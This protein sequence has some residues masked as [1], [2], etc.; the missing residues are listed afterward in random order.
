MV[1]GLAT[2][3]R[4][5]K[6]TTDQTSLGDPTKGPGWEGAYTLEAGFLSYFELLGGFPKETWHFNEKGQFL[7]A[8]DC[9]E[10][11]VSFEDEC[12][13][14][15]K[16]NWIR[17]EGFYGL[18]IWEV[19]SDQS[20]NKEFPLLNAIKKAAMGNPIALDSC[21]RSTDFDKVAP[22]FCPGKSKAPTPAPSTP[23][24]DDPSQPSATPAPSS[25]GGGGSSGGGSPSGGGGSSGGGSGGGSSGGGSS[26]GGSG[27]SGGG[28]GGGSCGGSCG[29]SGGPRTVTTTTT[30]TTTT[31]H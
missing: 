15:Y 1:I 11:Y 24:S 19:S 12:T 20:L 6:L 27:G 4:T 31:Y 25:S 13:L 16:T 26:G 14:T 22:H 7:W 2:Y 18:M 23:G 3:G 17:Q 8:S 10:T 5:Q 30:T 21:Q 28:S 29:C 9:K